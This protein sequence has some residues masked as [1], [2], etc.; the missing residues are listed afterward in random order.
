M[1]RILMT[2][3]RSADGFA[4]AVG[5]VMLLALIGFG[6]SMLFVLVT[7]LTNWVE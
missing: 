3:G 2:L 5:G 4:K 6:A 1:R 7:L